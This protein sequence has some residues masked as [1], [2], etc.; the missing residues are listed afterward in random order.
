MSIIDKYRQEIIEG[1]PIKWNGL[2]FHP[3]KVRQFALYQAARDSFELMQKSLPP[4]LARMS[5][6]PGLYA[7]DKWFLEQTGTVK[8]YFITAVRVIAAALGMEK[9]DTKSPLPVGITPL[10]DKDGTMKTLCIQP[11]PGD[12]PVLLSMGKMNELRELIAA[13]NGYT[14]PNENWNLELYRAAK[15]L[16][17]DGGG[18]P[19][20]Y[21]M[22]ALI[23]SVSVNTGIPANE[24]WDWEIRRFMKTQEAVDRKLDYLICTTAE[25]SQQIKFKDGSPCP[26]WKFPRAKGLPTGFKTVSELDRESGGLLAGSK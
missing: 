11:R 16:E 24:I 7:L 25:L 20:E 15:E 14:I 2:V 10:V 6:F 5:W 26:S 17:A 21:D 19:L 23:Y 18:T 9:T 3:L 4:K 22:E 1:K 13:Q 12:D 8:G